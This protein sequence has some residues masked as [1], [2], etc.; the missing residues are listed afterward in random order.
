MDHIGPSMQAAFE[1]L[2]EHI[3]QCEGADGAEVLSVYHQF[4]MKTRV[5]EY[6]A[7]YSL[8]GE[9]NDVPSGLSKCQLSAVGA[10]KVAHTGSYQNLGNAWSAGYQYARYRKLKVDRRLPAFE[11]YRNDSTQ[12]EPA[13]LLTDVYIPVR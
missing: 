12:V 9:Q 11:I 6:T 10:L 1:E 3:G 13:E 5:V 2:R 8:D 4:D 7:G